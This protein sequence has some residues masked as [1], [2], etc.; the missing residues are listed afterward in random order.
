[1]TAFGTVEIAVS[2]M[3]EG[4]YDFVTKPLNRHEILK[5]LDKAREK[6]HLLAENRRLRQQLASQQQRGGPMAGIVG[7]SEGIRSVLETIGDGIDN[8]CD[9]ITE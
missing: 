6:A 3:R 4:A 7:A 9:G 2:A 5:S 8:D 1:M